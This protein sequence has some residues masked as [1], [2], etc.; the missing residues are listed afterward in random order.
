[1]IYVLR[2]EKDI[3]CVEIMSTMYVECVF[4]IN[5]SIGFGANAPE[6]TF[7]TYNESVDCVWVFFNKRT[8]KRFCKTMKFTI[9]EWYNCVDNN[10]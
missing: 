5:G 7:F 4:P 6:G 8:L 10:K 9:K 2:K 1:M 3:C